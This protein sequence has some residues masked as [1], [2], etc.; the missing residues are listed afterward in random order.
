MDRLPFDPD[1]ARGSKPTDVE[2]SAKP[3]SRTAATSDTAISVSQLTGLIADALDDALPNTLHVVG[4]ISNFKRHGSG[5]LY[6]TLKDDRSELVCVIWR[7]A[8]AKLK[9]RPEDGMAVVLTGH[10]AV[11]ERAGKYQFYA[12]SIVPQGAGA[13]ELAFRQLREKLAAQGLFNP[14]HKKSLPRFPQRIGVITSATGAA[15]RDITTTLARRYPIAEIVLCPVAV[16]GPS[17]AAE[18]AAAIARL[19]RFVESADATTGEIDV[20]I[21]GRGGGSIEDLWAFNEEAVA[22]AIHASRVPIISAVGHETDTT[23]ADLVADVRAATPTAA[24]EIAAPDVADIRDELEY[25]RSHLNRGLRHALELA[26]SHLARIA[27]RPSLSKPMSIVEARHRKV[28]DLERDLICVARD[29]L[30]A[31]D[32]RVHRAQALLNQIDPRRSVST[33][34]RRLIDLQHRLRF[35]AQNAIANG[36][37]RADLTSQR[38]LSALLPIHVIKP[39][40]STVLKAE[41]S[42]TLSANHHVDELSQ[43]LRTSEARLAALDYRATLNRGFSITRASKS[44]RIVRNTADL[45]NGDRIITHLADGEVHSRVEDA[46]QKG[47]FD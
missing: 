4:E 10:V 16:Q 7:S 1:Q 42:L 22:R 31:L 26:R 39:R 5:H 36:R 14:A 34:A 17:A 23:I 18:I 24:A 21:V 6:F 44:G 37:R 3:K 9:F 32:R 11:F 40:R 30:T 25:R 47:L 27:Q 38:L 19:N 43:R 15:V 13:L 8:A 35:A 33:A 20:I 46:D 2:S 28:A 41:A 29:R 12:R 45:S